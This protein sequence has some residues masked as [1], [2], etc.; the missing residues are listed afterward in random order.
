MATA[1]DA[2]SISFDNGFGSLGNAWNVDKS[3]P[4]QVT[5]AGT[6]ALME[7]ATGPSAGHGY[8]TYTIEAKA[9]GTQPGP[10]IIFWPGDNQWPGQEL[11]LLEVTPDGSGRQY[12]TVHWNANGTNGYSTQ[13]LNGVSNGDF[14]QYQMIW[15]AGKITIKVDGQ[16]AASFTDHVP[17]DYAHGGMN[18][19]IGFMNNNNNTSLTVRQVDFT[20]LGGGVVAATAGNVATAAT[21]NVITAAVDKATTSGTQYDALGEPLKADGTVDWDALAATVTANHAAT[22]HWFW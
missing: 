5:F 6:S 11:D 3:V 19:T 15:E 18:D 17:V 8:G 12:A 9:T 22:G 10:G 14:H 1:T 16:Q 13:L 2:L 4:G 20:P 7:W 21:A